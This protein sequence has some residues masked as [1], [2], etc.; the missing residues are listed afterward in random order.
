MTDKRVAAVPAILPMAA[1]TPCFMLHSECLSSREF[2][3]V[4]LWKHAVIDVQLLHQDAL[5]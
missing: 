5:G 2:P 4:K 3:D 1:R